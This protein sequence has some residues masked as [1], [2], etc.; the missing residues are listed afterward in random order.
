MTYVL[1]KKTVTIEEFEN[2]EVFGIT[3]FNSD[4]IIMKVENISSK[5]QFVEHILDKFIK[6]GVSVYHVIDVIEDEILEHVG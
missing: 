4:S 5:M 6:Y 3:I 1:N 2:V